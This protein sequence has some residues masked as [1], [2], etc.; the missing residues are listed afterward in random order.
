MNPAFVWDITMVGKG[1]GDDV[2]KDVILWSATVGIMVWGAICYSSRC[3]LIFIQGSMT[4][5]RYIQEVLQPVT[6]L[7]FMAT[8]EPHSNKIT[9]NHKQLGYLLVC[10]V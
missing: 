8:K 7:L 3:P 10:N 9:L 5:H 2:V 6:I 1:L 4:A